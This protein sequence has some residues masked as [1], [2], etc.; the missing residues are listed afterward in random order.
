MISES[1]LSSLISSDAGLISKMGKLIKWH[2]LNVNTKCTH[3]ICRRV[4]TVMQC[5]DNDKFLI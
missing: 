4:K 3:T 5:P 2:K 1:D